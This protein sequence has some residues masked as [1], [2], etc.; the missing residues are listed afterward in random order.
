MSNR[1]HR[2]AAGC[3]GKPAPL[4]TV[5]TPAEIDPASIPLVSIGVSII[6]PDGRGHTAV[7]ALADI[8]DL[9]TEATEALATQFGPIADPTDAV[10]QA[11]GRRATA[12]LLDGVQT[13]ESALAATIGAL[14]A[15][16][17]HPTQ[18]GILAK[19]SEL[20]TG[21]GRG[22]LTVVAGPETWLFLVTGGP[23][24]ALE[25]YCR[26]APL[27]QASFVRPRDTSAPAPTH[28]APTNLQ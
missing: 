27:G 28:P 4:G 19:L 26:A 1:H 2:R 14:W 3:R 11:K 6:R 21:T 24:D 5:A 8:P 22:W 9:V 13:R 23:V 10:L 20:V 7:W 17:F 12:R 15:A 25:L 16:A 18:R